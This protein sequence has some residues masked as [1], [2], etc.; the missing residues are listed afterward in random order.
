MAGA[1]LGFILRLGAIVW[2]YLLQGNFLVAV[3]VGISLLLISILTFFIFTVGFKFSTN[4][5]TFYDNHCRCSRSSDLL[6]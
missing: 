5:C 6:L 4:V 2:A 3:V 1:L